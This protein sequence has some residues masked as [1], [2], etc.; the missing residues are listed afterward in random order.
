LA[1]AQP[2]TPNR[3]QIASMRGCPRSTCR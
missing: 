2:G 1:D 3:S